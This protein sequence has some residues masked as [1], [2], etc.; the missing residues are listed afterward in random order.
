[1]IVRFVTY[2]AWL[3]LFVIGQLNL[4]VAQPVPSVKLKILGRQTCEGLGACQGASLHDGF[5]YLYGDLY[6]KDRQPGPG[7]I[8][9]Y[10]FEKDD[11]GIPHLRDTELEIRLV[12]DG[13]N[14][15]NHPT[16]LTWNS[17]YGTY[18]GDTVTKTRK[19]TIY[20]LN[21]AQML[22]DR[23]LDHAILNVIDDD[24]AVQGCRPEFVRREQRWLLATADY[25]Q[26]N[27]AIRFYDPELLS[28]VRTTSSSSVLVEQLATSPWVQQLHWVDSCNLIVLAQN[29]IEG[30]RW[31]LTVANPWKISAAGDLKSVPPCDDITDSTELEGFTMLDREFCLLVSS[32]RT[33]NVTIA[34]TQPQSFWILDL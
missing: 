11:Q 33:D 2:L 30:R 14:L 23:N 10:S 19:G 27:N 9:Q 13:N 34:Y 31:R 24:L 3:S 28:T 17:T 16:G 12:R 7:V 26:V 18:L 25:G 1:M 29:Q 5:V 20:H 21:W 32:S 4:A 8:R 15:I 22:I 6:L